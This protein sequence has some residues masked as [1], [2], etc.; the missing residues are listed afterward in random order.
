M[1]RLM[2][3]LNCSNHLLVSLIKTSSLTPHHQHC[4]DVTTELDLPNDEF[5]V[6]DSVSDISHPDVRCEFTHA[7]AVAVAD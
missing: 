4:S 5:H 6:T 2:T 3:V 7:D 1:A